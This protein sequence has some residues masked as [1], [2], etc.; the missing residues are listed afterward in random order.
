MLQ[1]HREKQ[2]AVD[3][4]VEAQPEEGFGYEAEGKDRAAEKHK[5][6]QSGKFGVSS[7][8]GVLLSEK[9]I[10]QKSQNEAADYYSGCDAIAAA[11]VCGGSADVYAV[12]GG[13]GKYE[14]HDWQKRRYGYGGQGGKHGGLQGHG[15]FAPVP[16]QPDGINENR[17][18]RRLVEEGGDH[19]EKNEKRR[20]VVADKDIRQKDQSY[21]NELAHEVESHGIKEDSENENAQKCLLFQNH[22]ACYVNEWNG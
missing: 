21:A 1:D 7:P 6:C 9:I 8:L 16:K 11:A 15:A 20:L 3:E 10:V 18:E 22:P 13:R 2:Y 17:Y 14:A 12:V 4:E 5:V 19:D